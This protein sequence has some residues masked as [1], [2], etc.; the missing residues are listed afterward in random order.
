MM[1]CTQCNG[2]KVMVGQEG[3]KDSSSNTNSF[4]PSAGDVPRTS[5]SQCNGTGIQNSFGS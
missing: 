2:S 3:L 4:Q 1:V 5:C